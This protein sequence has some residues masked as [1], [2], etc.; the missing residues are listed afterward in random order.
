MFFTVL[1]ATTVL[2]LSPITELPAEFWGIVPELK[3]VTLDTV[4]R[5]Q[6]RAVVFVH[7]LLPRVLHPERATKPGLHDWQMP[8]STI[9][10]EL[11]TDCDLYGLS[12]AQVFST[13]AI[14]MSAVLRDGIEMLKSTGYKEIVLL[15][16]SAGAI[17][18]REFVEA[19]PKS[20]VT[21]VISVCGPHLGSGWAQLPNFT[22]PKT[23]L[24]FINSLHPDVRAARLKEYPSVIEGRLE[25]CCLICK[26][27]RTDHDTVVSLRSQWPDDLQDNG[28]PAVVVPCTHFDVMISDVGVRAICE[29][30]RNRVVR[31]KPEQLAA[32][33][34][35]LFG[36]AKP[37]K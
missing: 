34:L 24:N 23:Q 17:V 28:V 11:K 9:V 18:C 35:Q 7:G 37:A 26:F 15:G 2:T 32:A 16:H 22:L 6:D 1:T 30:V 29:V 25:Y 12:Y 10:K 3:L 36:D 21:K 4:K 27:R 31:W 14:A 5:K 19:F 20:G 33:R 13:D 8:D